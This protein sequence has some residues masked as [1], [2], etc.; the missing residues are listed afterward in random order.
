MRKRASFQLRCVKA[1]QVFFVRGKEKENRLWQYW[2]FGL[3]LTH[4]PGSAGGVRISERER[5]REGEGER[6]EVH[7]AV[8]TFF[9]ATF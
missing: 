1:Q 8:I 9:S 2:V 6:E 5:D 3:L 7:L 4:L